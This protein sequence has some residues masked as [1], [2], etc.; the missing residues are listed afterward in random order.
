MD[1]AADSLI[2]RKPYGRGFTYK[3]LD[4]NETLKDVQKKKWIKSLA[5]PPAWSGVHID[6]NKKAKVL[7]WGR[8]LKERK[9]YIYNESFRAKKEQEKFDRMIEFGKMLPVMRKKTS[10]HL[11]K[12]KLSKEKVLAL[13]VRLL[14]TAYFRAGSQYYADE[15]DTYGLTTLRSKHLKITDGEAYFY[16]CGKSGKFQEKV[17]ENKKL[18]KILKKLDA[19]P[20]YEIFK[21]VDDKGNKHDIDRDMLNDY[22]KSTMG[23]KF[24]AKDFRTWAGTY[25]AATILDKIGICD[26]KSKIEK[27]IIEAVDDVAAK[28]GNTRD[29][30]RSS[31]I[32]PRVI[33]LYS[34]GKTIRQYTKEVQSELKQS[35][36]CRVEELAIQKLLENEL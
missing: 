13:M 15:N 7:A 29:V 4:T 19:I 20:G 23:E 9:Q 10:E 17:I 14:D 25:L 31:Y 18:T 26:E 34:E 2:L 32:D 11:K 21:Y 36:L 27:N 22:I 16:Y 30:A 33:E 3:Y 8:D 28:L 6:L 35:R 24:S 12:K 1:N 5:I